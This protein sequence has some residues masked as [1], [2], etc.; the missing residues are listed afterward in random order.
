MY[1]I[2]LENTGFED[3]D[4]T[5]DAEFLKLT[6]LLGLQDYDSTTLCLYSGNAH[7]YEDYSDEFTC[8]SCIRIAK[9]FFH[10]YKKKDFKN[11]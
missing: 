6:H 11:L 4:E 9:E 5:L 1:L 2:K 10:K 7:M 8:S 3:N